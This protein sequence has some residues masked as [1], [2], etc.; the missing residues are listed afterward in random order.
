MTNKLE[1]TDQFIEEKIKE[2]KVPG[3]AIAV[4]KDN[5]TVYKKSFGYRDIKRNLK[6]T[7]DT[8]FPIASCSKAFGS[9]ALGILV[10][11]GKL[12]W[13][14][15]VRD[16]IPSF[17]ILDSYAS[18]RITARDLLC[19]R[20]GL[21]RHDG[22]WYASY[23][24]RKDIF[25]RLKYLNSSAGF[26][27]KWQYNN[28]MYMAVSFLI[29]EITGNPWEKFVREKI[30]APLE[31]NSTSFSR[32]EGGKN[33][34]L[35]Y[36]EKDG[37]L[38]EMTPVG[39]ENIGTAGCMNST[40]SDMAN[41]LILNLNKGR[42]KDKQILSQEILKEIHT[43]QV[44]TGEP[45]EFKE[46]FYKTYALGWWVSMYCNRIFL[47]HTGGV[48]G[49]SSYTGF[50]PE[51]NT[52]I[53]ILTNKRRT[54]LRFA[55]AFDIYT[56]IMSCKEISWYEIMKKEEKKEN[57]K[58]QKEKEKKHKNRKKNTTPSHPLKDYRGKFHHPAYGELIIE[59][60]KNC[61]FLNYNN[62][63]I[64]LIQYH[65][66]IFNPADESVYEN[67][68]LKFITDITGKIQKISV[69]ME[70]TVESV[71]FTRI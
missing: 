13:D 62:H 60:K 70:E 71:I 61:L 50:M 24:S 21:A 22:M 46:F 30:L 54:Y 40:I 7:P 5:T 23:Y 44:L 64:P 9:T 49:Y 53:V 35:P 45:R 66:D 14:K 18:A 41:W 34:A 15:P 32:T 3:I 55:I 63:S 33:F 2:W 56:R 25:S 29:E 36:K 28:L 4:V 59:K 51:E 69:D 31:M 26:R 27:E 37:E 20:T 68:T 47:Y 42:F 8:V 58:A 1:Y 6:V 10:E 19:H 12:D 48:D 17:Q 11:E 16:Y 43:P 52:G 38:L 65:Y 67:I 39:L 57:E